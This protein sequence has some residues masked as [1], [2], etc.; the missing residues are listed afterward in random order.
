[1]SPHSLRHSYA[2]HLIEAGVDL[3][4]V[5]KILGHTSILSTIR[6]THLTQKTEFN[7][8]LQINALMDT[9]PVSWGKVV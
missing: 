4:E 1:M 8:A 7:R 9:F 2:T 5:Q 3:L 6:Y